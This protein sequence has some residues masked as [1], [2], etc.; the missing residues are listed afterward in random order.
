MSFK[1]IATAF[2]F[3]TVCH[4]GL[5]AAP[6]ADK[7][8]DLKTSVIEIMDR[9]DIPALGI[10]MIDE[11]GPVWVGA[12]G[13]A[14]LELDIDADKHS[15]FRIASTSKMFVAL[16][17]LKLAEE[18]RLSLQD[19]LADLAP[20]VVFGNLATRNPVFVYQLRP[21]RGRLCG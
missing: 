12:V 4:S 20:E 6:Q 9:Y 16:S 18:G 19:K 8:Q 5:S 17:V 21:C 13:S 7:L 14:N 15:I 2:V 10:A 1:T 11:N 3:L